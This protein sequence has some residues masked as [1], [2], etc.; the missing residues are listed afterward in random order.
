MKSIPSWKAQA[1]AVLINAN[2][3][4]GAAI[5]LANMK[6]GVSKA[7]KKTIKK[8]TSIKTKVKE[9]NPVFNLAQALK[10]VKEEL[11]D[12]NYFSYK[13]RGIAGRYRKLSEK[14]LPH[15]IKGAIAL[16]NSD[17]LDTK[18]KASIKTALNGIQNPS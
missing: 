12:I 1:I 6:F 15:L 10:P 8:T 16:L 5:K 3:K 14:Q 9:T 4:R 2:S 18:Q 7:S 11:K 17:K 13:M